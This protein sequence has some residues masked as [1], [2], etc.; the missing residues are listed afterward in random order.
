MKEINILKFYGILLVVLGHVAFTYS[1]MSIITPN[2]PSVTLNMLKEIIYS[3]HMP[4]FFFASGCV[5]AWQLEVKRKAMTV[6]QLFK[7]KAKRLMI[8][9]YVFGLLLVYPTM[10]LLGLRDPVHYFFDGFV[11]AIDPRH[12]WFVMTLFIVFLLFFCLRKVCMNYH[13]PTWGIAIVALFLY[14]VPINTVYFQ[15]ITVEEYFVWFVLGYLFVL[16]RK[17]IQISFA[18]VVVCGGCLNFCQS[19]F[20]PPDLLKIVNAIIGI[21]VFYI[22]SV[23]TLKVENTRVYK[24]IAPNSFGIYLFHAMIIY[25]LEFISVPYGINPILL[26]SCVF[27]ISLSL[28]IIL[29]VAVRRLGFGFIIGEKPKH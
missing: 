7:N 28:S 14:Y 9:F 19:E 25:W 20:T 21:T 10:V 1:P 3:F 6:V 2:A 27:V 26:S 8:P 17:V 15:I 13:I 18:A 16:Y 11:I 5:F 29:T 23:K 4:L 24:W 22:L 12:L